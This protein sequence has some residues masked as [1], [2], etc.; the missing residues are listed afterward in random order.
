MNE[1]RLQKFFTDAGVM[2]RRAAEKEIQNGNVKVNGRVAELGVKVNP[3]KDII[4]F[5]GKRIV[6][7][8]KEYHYLIINKPRGYICTMNDPQGRKCVTELV[9]DYPHRVYPVGRLDMIS[10]GILLMTDDGDLANK[11]IH[12]S[13][14]IPKVYR[15][16]V[17]GEVSK[18]QYTALTSPMIIDGYKIRPVEVEITS[19]DESG[20]VMKMTLREG[21]NRQIRKMCESVGLA[22]KRLNRVS[23]GTLKLNNLRLGTWRELEEDEV[24]YLKNNVK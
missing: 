10:E 4:T 14:S 19:S 24:K 13:H 21:R 7:Q 18:E 16:K 2:S 1:I 9:K 12:P 15:V 3:T 5:N 11:M 8:N 20:T 23:I 6:P 22:V 17:E